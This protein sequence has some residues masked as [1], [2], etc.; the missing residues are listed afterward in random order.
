M[1]QI[2]WDPSSGSIKSASLKLLVMFCVHSRCLAACN[3]DLWCVCSSQLGASDTHTTDPNFML[4]NT[5]Y[6][7][8][9]SQAISVKHF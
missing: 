7:H 9:T 2:L 1:F 6:A 8:K 5:D 3:L 4:P